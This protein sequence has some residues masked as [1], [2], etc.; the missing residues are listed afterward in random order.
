MPV[1]AAR[2]GS[3]LR[4]HLRFAVAKL[5]VS[6]P[7]KTR[8]RLSPS[9]VASWLPLRSGIATLAARSAAGKEATYLLRLTLAPPASQATATPAPLDRGRWV[10]APSSA[11]P[12][13]AGPVTVGIRYLYV[14]RTH[15]GIRAAYFAGRLWRARPPLTDGSGNPPRGWANP[16]SVG[17]MRLV[18][19]DAAEFRQSE[20][21]VARFSPAPRH[22]KTL[23]CE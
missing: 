12:G 6:Y 15:C 13:C 10:C 23:A 18:R 20:K 2:A 22:W 11:R 19:G 4:F 8:Q 1:V 3:R 9:S 17:T 5:T 21:L 14:L 7:D 16:E